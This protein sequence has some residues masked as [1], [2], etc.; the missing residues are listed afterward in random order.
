MPYG[1]IK[2]IPGVNVERTPTLN[3]AGI[4]QSR[5]IRFKDS[6]VQKLGGWARFYPNA[7]AG[8]PR[9]LHAWEDLNAT[10]H[11]CVGSTTQL[12]VIT[13]G[14]LLDITPQ[15]LTS[16]FAPNFNTAA[17]SP[18]VEVV[19]PNVSNVT[20]YDAVFFNTPG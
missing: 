5:L 4:S 6:L 1:S 14:T 2:L 17:G 9:D 7:V 19:D 20:T 18:L 8:T 11:L 16:D 10:S 3:Q 13:A 12:A 15:R